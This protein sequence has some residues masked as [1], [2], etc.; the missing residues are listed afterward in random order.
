MASKG[1]PLPALDYVQDSLCSLQSR[2]Q[3]LF[4]G[5][6]REAGKLTTREWR[7]DLDYVVAQAKALPTDVQKGAGRTFKAFEAST[8]KLFSE[9]QTFAGKQLQPVVSRLSLPSK[10][11]VELLAER[12]AVLE[13]KV[14]DLHREEPEGA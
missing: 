8:S 9:V 3:E 7:R 2:V 13:K 14:E 12:L 10:H 1:A 11:E 5:I 6:R 4:D